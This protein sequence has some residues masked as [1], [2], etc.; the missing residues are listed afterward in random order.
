MVTNPDD[1]YKLARVYQIPH[2]ELLSPLRSD[3]LYEPV[4]KALKELAKALRE[5]TELPVPPKEGSDARVIVKAC[6][7]DPDSSRSYAVVAVKILWRKDGK[8][9]QLGGYMNT[10]PVT[11]ALAALGNGMLPAY[12]DVK[13][14]EY[15]W[16]DA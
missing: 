7:Y 14:S 11:T 8:P 1:Y 5:Q 4:D 9:M 3:S 12:W 2:E 6:G 10:K 13:F 16:P 15:M